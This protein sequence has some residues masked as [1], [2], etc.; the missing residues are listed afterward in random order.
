MTARDDFLAEAHVAI[1]GTVDS[2]N[3]PHATP[4]WYLYD[5]GEFRFSIGRGSQKHRNLEANPEMS[6][7]VDQRTMPYYAV[8]M[9]GAAAFGPPL[10]DEDH[11]KLAVRYLGEEVGRRYT[12]ATK[13]GDVLTVHFRPRKTIEYDPLGSRRG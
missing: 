11:L 9:R 13:G 1:I 3:R 12:E 2:K 8:M 6:L 7:V 4:I 10:S 5:G